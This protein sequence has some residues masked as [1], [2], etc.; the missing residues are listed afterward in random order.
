MKTYKN[1]KNI[2]KNIKKKNITKNIKK[3]YKKKKHF[4]KGGDNPPDCIQTTNLDLVGSQDNYLSKIYTIT[5]DP[6]TLSN[7]CLEWIKNKLIELKN[8]INNNERY[9]KGL[10]P[11]NDF[12]TFFNYNNNDI[13]NVDLIFKFQMLMNKI[14][15]F[16]LN[17]TKKVMRIFF[18]SDLLDFFFGGV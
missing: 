2:A 13:K 8:I 5:T 14:Q 16:K 1:E 11:N 12:D 6:N 10:F 4:Q 18:I 17:N 7:D 15:N 3:T 9:K